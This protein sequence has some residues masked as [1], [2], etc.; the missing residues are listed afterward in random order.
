[1]NN[2]HRQFAS[3]KI[4]D[5][6]AYEHVGNA[7]SAPLPAH[8]RH[9]SQSV[10]YG[11]SRAVAL[12]E[13]KARVKQ[14]LVPSLNRVAS[15][16][17]FQMTG[18]QRG[19]IEIDEEFNIEVDGLAINKLSGSGKAVAN[20]AI[21][22]GLGQVLTN[23]VFSVFMGDEIDAAMDADRAGYTA[24]AMQRLTKHVSQVLLVSHKEHDADQHIHLGDES[25]EA[26]AA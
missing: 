10:G 18:G 19:R 1:M 20:L 11:I 23:R 15:S 22:I 25:A 2:V 16:L 4:C 3:A 14:Y 6:P 26:N 8:K 7:A 9:R 5:R 24:Q 21:R 17:L 13:L 12:V